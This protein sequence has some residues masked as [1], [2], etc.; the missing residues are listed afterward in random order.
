MT[1]LKESRCAEYYEGEYFYFTSK[2]SLKFSKNM[3]LSF[4]QINASGDNQ[5]T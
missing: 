3:A 4:N 2:T 5:Y 1:E